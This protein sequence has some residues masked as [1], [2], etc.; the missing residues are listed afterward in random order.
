LVLQVRSQGLGADRNVLSQ[1]CIEPQFFD[2]A[3]HNPISE[4]TMLSV[5][6]Y[7]LQCN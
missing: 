1:P 2:H 6:I 3:V 5:Y 4:M 7:V